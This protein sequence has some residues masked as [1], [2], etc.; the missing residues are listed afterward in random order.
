M[1]R[2]PLILW[3]SAIIAV[4]IVVI[5]IVAI[6]GGDAASDA[7]AGDADVQCDAVS[8]AGDDP[9]AFVARLEPGDTGCLRS[10]SHVASGTV[11]LAEPGVTLTGYPGESATLVGRIWVKEGADGVVIEN[12][13]L[14]GRN[15]DDLPSPTVNADDVVFRG[16]DVTNDHTAICF[17]IGDDRFGE[18]DGTVIEGNRVHDCGQLPATNHEHGIYVAFARGTAIRDNAIFDNADRGVQLYPNADDSSVTGNVIEGNGQ[19]VI[20]GGDESHS[21]DGN[22]VAGNVITNST[23][24]FNVESHWQGPVGRG[25]VARDNCVWTASDEY[26]GEPP[27]SGIEAAMSGVEATDNVVAEPDYSDADNGD[28]RI[29]GETAC[30]VPAAAAP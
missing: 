19:G 6:A 30:E 4:A 18:S 3:L 17:V 24:R 9:A 8:V 15:E 26:G 20:F 1:R 13:S 21:S 25:N 11:A 10:G 16:N 22:V 12:L 28:L 14:D 5:A 23:I 27:G 7:P 2:G 29:D